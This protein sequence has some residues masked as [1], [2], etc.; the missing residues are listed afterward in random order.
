MAMLRRW[1]VP[2]RGYEVAQNNLAY[3]LD[4]GTI[5]STYIDIWFS[6]TV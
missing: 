6:S 3:L 2:E 1:M 5:T 4:Q